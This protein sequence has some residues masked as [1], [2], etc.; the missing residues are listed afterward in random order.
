MLHF[1]GKISYTIREVNL[2]DHTTES[3]L[4]KWQMNKKNLKEQNIMKISDKIEEMCFKA[5]QGKAL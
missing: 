5:S 1:P 3:I 2:S 4:P